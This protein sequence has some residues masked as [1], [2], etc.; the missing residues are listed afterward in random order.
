MLVSV[1]G[2]RVQVTVFFTG[3]V[4]PGRFKDGRFSESE[5]DVVS[6]HFVK[7]ILARE[8]LS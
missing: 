8:S 7:C 1:V 6:C 2:H 4:L 5:A 3:F